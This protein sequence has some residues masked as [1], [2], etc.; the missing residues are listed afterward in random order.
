V[1]DEELLPSHCR[2][3]TDRVMLIQGDMDAAE[4]GKGLLEELQRRDAKLHS[5]ES[6]S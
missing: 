6:T 1:A 2:F 3:R 4:K 5:N